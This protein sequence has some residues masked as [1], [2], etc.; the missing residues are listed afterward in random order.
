MRADDSTA[1]IVEIGT[2]RLA[3]E[4]AVLAIPA[5]DIVA[6]D[7]PPPGPIPST[8]CPSS[9]TVPAGPF[10]MMRGSSTATARPLRNSIWKRSTLTAPTRSS[11]SPAWGFGVGTVSHCRFSGGPNSL[12]TTACMLAF[13]PPGMGSPQE[14]NE[15]FV[16][17]RCGLWPRRSTHQQKRTNKT[18]PDGPTP[19][20]TCTEF[21]SFLSCSSNSLLS[22]MVP[23]S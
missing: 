7:D 15:D 21:Q 18:A 14:M 8:P 11:T 2:E 17:C 10:P 20:R 19:F 13:T 23:G 22:G 4:P 3:A 5:T 6:D 9:T 12:R 16:Y 1:M